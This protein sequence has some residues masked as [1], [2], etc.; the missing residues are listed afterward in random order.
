VFA[1]LDLVK[2]SAEV[3]SDGDFPINPS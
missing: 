3:D 1:F 2:S